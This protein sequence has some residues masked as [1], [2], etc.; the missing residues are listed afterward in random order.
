M[1]STRLPNSKSSCPFSNIL[2]TVPKA[3]TTIGII[4]TFML[5]IFFNSLAKSRY[6]SFFSLS[7]SFIL[8]SAATTN[9]TILQVPFFLLIIIR[10]GS[11]AEIRWFVSIS[12]SQWNLFVS[13]S[14][15]DLGLC[16]YYLLVWL[17][18]NLLH[19]SQWITLPTQTCLVLY[20]FCDNLLHSFIWLMVSSL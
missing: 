7:F 13:F 10:S 16:I 18:F 9:S 5:H 12:K 14:K 15:T 4:A 3:P 1:V 17:N 8:W 19:I 20:T 2:V 11:L 6:L